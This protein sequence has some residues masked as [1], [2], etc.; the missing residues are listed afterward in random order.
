MRL[1]VIG[2]GPLRDDLEQQVKSL[3]LEQVVDF[4][5]YVEREK[6]LYGYLRN[7]DIFVLTSVTEGF[8]R[9]LYEAMTHRLPIISTKVGGIPYFLEDQKDAILCDIND[10]CA[11]SAAID[12]VISEKI[13]RMR[14]ISNA[15]VKMEQVFERSN[16]HQIFELLK[17]RI[18]NKR[19]S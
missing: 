1:T 12:R 6:E 3:N 14:L 18:S 17:S 2:E 19:H 13:L 8:P 4:V 10:V 15:N 9:V 16:P 7:S 11:L 5:G